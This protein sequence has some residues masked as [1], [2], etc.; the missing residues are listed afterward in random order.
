M[1]R[2]TLIPR[3]VTYC[4]AGR[5]GVDRRDTYP[6]G[7]GNGVNLLRESANFALLIVLSSFQH[8]LR[9]VRLVTRLLRGWIVS[10]VVHLLVSLDTTV[11]EFI[12]HNR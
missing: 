6:P 2:G 7:R 4:Q 8:M 1:E 9:M 12:Q 3:H 5:V 10:Q 11:L